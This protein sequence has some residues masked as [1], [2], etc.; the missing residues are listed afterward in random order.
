MR[1]KKLYEF[2]LN[3]IVEVA[4]KKD[5]TIKLCIVRWIS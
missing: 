1:Y 3:D 5:L 4:E 2:N